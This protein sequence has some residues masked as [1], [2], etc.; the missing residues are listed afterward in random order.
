M[1]D[2]LS[3]QEVMEN[4]E[5]TETVDIVDGMDATTLSSVLVENGGNKYA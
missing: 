3:V 5:F 2:V 1:Q 4:M